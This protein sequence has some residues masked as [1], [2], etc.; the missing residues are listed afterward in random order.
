MSLRLPE[1]WVFLRPQQALMLVIQG[2]ITRVIS[3]LILRPGQ[4]LAKGVTPFRN[5]KGATITTPSKDVKG[6]ASDSQ[7]AVSLL[8]S[9][10]PMAADISPPSSMVSTFVHATINPAI[11]FA[12]PIFFST[13]S[14][15]TYILRQSPYLGASRHIHVAPVAF[16]GGLA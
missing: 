9:E 12:L 5:I 8:C 11:A 4:K 13:C 16:P 14:I 15:S 3:I 6:L 10:L 2:R 1:R 7:R